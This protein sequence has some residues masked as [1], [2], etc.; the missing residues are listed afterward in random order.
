MFSAINT[1]KLL[2]KTLKLFEYLGAYAYS[3]SNNQVVIKFSDSRMCSIII[4]D[5][6]NAQGLQ[7]KFNIR[8]DIAKSTKVKNGTVWRCYYTLDNTNELVYDLIE[9]HK[10]MQ[11]WEIKTTPYGENQ[12]QKLNTKHLKSN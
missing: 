8:S 6:E 3:S 4:S 9:R 10:K 12:T 2:L 5:H 11:T 7:Y 1:A